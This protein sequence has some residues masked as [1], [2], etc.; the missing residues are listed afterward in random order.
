MSEFQYT[1]ISFS[2]VTQFDS[3]TLIAF[4]HA[5]DFNTPQSAHN[6]VIKYR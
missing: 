4:L 3:K 1:V 5:L 6:M 2:F